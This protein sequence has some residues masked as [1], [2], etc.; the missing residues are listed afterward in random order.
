[1]SR[2]RQK[3]DQLGVG[4][5][6]LARLKN[7]AAGWRRERMLAIKLA[8]EGKCTQNV[9]DDLGRSQATIQTWINRFREGLGLDKVPLQLIFKDKASQRGGT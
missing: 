2:P 3:I 9:A 5:E 1:M 6:L 7:E 4:S 8:M